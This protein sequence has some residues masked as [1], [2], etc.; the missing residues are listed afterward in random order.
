MNEHLSLSN[1]ERI[2]R[3]LVSGLYEYVQVSSNV[4]VEFFQHFLIPI[5]TFGVLKLCAIHPEQIFLTPK[6]SCK[7]DCIA[8]GDIPIHFAQFSRH[9]SVLTHDH[10]EVM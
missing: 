10:D 3:C 1:I 6:C 8:V 4:M 9:S 7:I 5:N 2:D